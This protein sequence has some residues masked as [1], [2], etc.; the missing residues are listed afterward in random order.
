MNTLNRD[1]SGWKAV[2]LLSGLA[3]SGLSY[4]VPNIQGKLTHKIVTPTNNATVSVIDPVTVAWDTTSSTYD[5]DYAYF[6]LRYEDQDGNKTTLRPGK[7]TS[8]NLGTLE[9]GS[10][11]FNVRGV[12]VYTDGTTKYGLYSSPVTVNVPNPVGSAQTHSVNALPSSISHKKGLTVSWSGNNSLYNSLDY[13]YFMLSQTGAASKI[14]RPGN[15]SQGITNLAPNSQYCFKVRAIYKGKFGPYSSN[16]CTTTFYDIDGETTHRINAPDEHDRTKPLR[17]TWSLNSGYDGVN[18]DR[19]TL[20]HSK[21]GNT[22]ASTIEYSAFKDFNANE[23]ETG[24]HCFSVAARFNGI[25]GGRS[26]EKCVTIYSE[27]T[28]LFKS[29]GISAVPTHNPTPMCMP[30][31]MYARWHKEVYNGPTAS[32]SRNGHIVGVSK[33]A[34]NTDGTITYNLGNNKYENCDLKD[35]DD[36]IAPVQLTTDAQTIVNQ[37]Q[38]VNNAMLYVKTHTCTTN[39]ACLESGKNRAEL[40]YD[41]KKYKRSLFRDGDTHTQEGDVFWVTYRF[42]AVNLFDTGTLPANTYVY[43]SQFHNDTT[44]IIEE[45]ID[46]CSPDNHCGPAPTFGMILQPVNES[47]KAKLTFRTKYVGRNAAGNRKNGVKDLNISNPISLKQWYQVKIGIKFST[48]DALL[49]NGSRN[50]SAGWAVAAIRPD[51]GEWEYFREA[52]VPQS[53]GSLFRGQTL[54]AAPC[55]Y[56]KDGKSWGPEGWDCQSTSQRHFETVFK[57][58][59][60]FNADLWKNSVNNHLEVL[61]D[62]VYAFDN[63]HESAHNRWPH[64][65]EELNDPLK[66]HNDIENIGFTELELPVSVVKFPQ[67][68]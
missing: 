37:E 43:L 6:M 14:Y 64:I 66:N 22:Q 11:T 60:Y 67:P 68:D 38:D 16:V 9:V 3:C 21:P 7:N 61:F 49:A 58:G 56:N 31:D 47:G 33:G 40:S 44:E 28:N 15:S 48:E 10:H 36:T 41:S 8:M 13:D 2:L 55:R 45:Y 4:A 1:I 27:A 39:N 26:V 46:D 19:Y 52:G 50:P 20:Y 54:H 25:D 34:L 57:F 17:L 65:K 5:I 51:G 62:D 30:S 63:H 12:Q 59:A 18:P 35:N 53:S 23:L 32:G 42:N 29:E 24:E